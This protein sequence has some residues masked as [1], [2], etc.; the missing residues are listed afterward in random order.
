MKKLP[1]LL[2]AGILMS[3]CEKIMFKE[4]LASDN[5]RANFE[6][7]WKQC[8]D[9][10]AFMQY[11]KVDWQAVYNK[12]SPRVS[13]GISKD[14]LFNTMALMLNELRDG[15]VNL[16]S[17]FNISVYSFH[18]KGPVNFSQRL[19]EEKYLSKPFFITGPFVHSF[20]DS[21]R[22]GYIQFK[23][24]TGTVTEDQLDY[25]LG[26]YQNTRGLILDLRENGGGAATDIY[27]IMGRFVESKTK[28]FTTK[29]KSG[30][31]ADDFSAGLESFLEPYEGLRYKNKL[32]V[33]CDR[34]TYSAGSYTSLATKAL[35]HVIL[36]GDTTGG[37]LG[38]PN[39]GQLPNGWTYRFSVTQTL[40][41]QGNNY[42]DG[43]PPDIRLV[44]DPA[45]LAKGKD[46]VI[47]RAVEEL[48]K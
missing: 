42:E 28:I 43:V 22:I 18:Q 21:G 25:I 46:S 44:L 37:G 30:P 5:P 39:G 1:T 38:M 27:K 17:P 35:D 31:G 14:S 41:L 12:Y 47:E 23:A 13:E 40:D 15:H 33:L 8:R 4:D 32:A 11:K 6:Y 20:I 24:F 45:D 2:L 34:G 16:I 29:D 36:I 48:K 9:K 10:Y 7:L 26:K 19:I 3:S